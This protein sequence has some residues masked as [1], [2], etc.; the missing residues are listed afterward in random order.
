MRIER[1]NDSVCVTSRNVVAWPAGVK[2][3]LLT[4]L[5]TTKLPKFVEL[6]ALN[7]SMRYSRPV[8]SVNLNLLAIARFRLSSPGASC[9]LRPTVRALGRPMPSI[10]CTVAGSQQAC[11]LALDPSNTS[12]LEYP[13]G[14]PESIVARVLR[15]AARWLMSGRSGPDWQWPFK[16]VLLHMV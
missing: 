7:I 3:L 2:L 6:S 9:V 13:S 10:Q 5:G 1:P 4:A 8:R 16:Y 12:G 15:G 14:H 11:L